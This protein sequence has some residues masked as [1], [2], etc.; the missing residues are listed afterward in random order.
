M[1]N[2]SWTEGHINGIW[3]VPKRTFRVFPPCDTES[4]QVSE[5]RPDSH[6]KHP[7]TKPSRS[8][9]FHRALLWFCS[10]CLFSWHS[11]SVSLTNET[12]LL[13]KLKERGRYMGLRTID[14]CLALIGP[15]VQIRAVCLVVGSEK[16]I[17][18]DLEAV[19]IV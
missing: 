18:L 8:R 16:G 7:I 10:W 9:F 14:E 13:N 12:L 17:S 15:S 11:Y 2:S 5:N 3:G 1:V 4:L 6:M 19:A